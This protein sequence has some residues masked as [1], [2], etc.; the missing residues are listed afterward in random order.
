MLSRVASTLALLCV[1]SAAAEGAT[2]F[3][4]ALRFRVQPT[5]HFRIYFDQRSAWLAPY[6]ATIAEE[7]WTQ[8]HRR[9]GGRA[10][11]MTHVVI[12]DQTDLSNGYATPLPYDTIVIYP[13]WPPGAEFNTDDWLRLVFTHEFTHIV[14]LDRSESWARI[15]RGVFGRTL[16]AFPNLFLPTWQIEGLATY[17]E[18][19]VTGRGRLHAGDFRAIVDE[20]ARTRR[21]EPLDRV[22]G[23]VTDWPGGQAAYAYGAAFH[24]F[25]ADRFGA[26]RLAALA[27]ATAGRLPYTAAPSFKTVFGESLGSLWRDFEVAR[28]RDAARAGPDPAVTRLTSSG[29]ITAAPRFDWTC[30]QCPLSIVYTT[31]TPHEFPSLN[32]IAIDGGAATTLTTRYS[33]ATTAVGK[34]KMYFDQ[35]EVARAVGVYGDLYE[36]SRDSNR[37][38]RLTRG[39]RLHDPD[40]SP[41]GTTIA[42]VQENASRRDLVLVHLTPAISIE[43]VAGGP[44]IHFNAPRWSPSGDRIAVERHVR[45]GDPEIVIMNT[46][47]RVFQVLLPVP[48][49]RMVMPAWRPDGRT[50]VAAVATGNEP[51]NLVEF[52]LDDKRSRRLTDIHGGATWPD[53]SPDGRTIVF[54]GYTSTGYDLFTMAYPDARVEWQPASAVAAWPSEPASV[55]DVSFADSVRTIAASEPAYSPV[56]TLKPTSWSPI[57]V[58][59]SDQ[60][61][62]GAETA[63]RDVLG[64][65]AWVTSAT[66]LVASPSET[67]APDRGVPDWFVSYAYDRWQPVLFASASAQTSFFAGPATSV[68]TPSTATRRERVFEGGVLLPMVRARRSHLALATFFRSADDYTLI[69]RNLRRD[70]AALRSGW[71]TTTAR[72][73]GYSISPEDG[74]IAGATGEFVRS[75]LGATADSTTITGDLRFFAHG[76]GRHHIV[77]GRLAGGAS[78]GDQIAGRTFVLGGSGPDAT[79]LDFGS[80]AISVL[81]GFPSNSFAGSRVALAQLEYRFPL[82]RPQR[83]V[84]TWPLFLHTVHAAAFADFGHAWTSRFNSADVKTSFGGELSTNVVAG[85]YF[86]FTLSVGAARGHDG[87]GTL[88]DRN[89]FYVRLGRSF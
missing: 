86:P 76:L 2:R 53:V 82:A 62:V 89:T 10:P 14:H 39:A 60:V 26:D 85:Y 64:Y 11:R 78:R 37:V 69:D 48:G 49:T 63:G 38:T 68:G 57:I 70:R 24:E 17:E 77:A 35:L 29:F 44:D 81:R 4:P 21:L 40:L 3:D 28:T 54:V 5:P 16:V 31:R 15:V 71:Q 72:T 34:Q 46:A 22:N 51:F 45:G 27:D 79:V 32:R 50:I 9:L 43:T 58:A 83:G 13:T 42:M 61:R 67:A 23:G 55:F 6:L 47:T 56:S 74:L 66:W 59:D 12:A 8:I 87:S 75:A 30:E 33:G 7:T 84:G 80:G 73:Y 36:L 19:T 88:P 65:H 20:A 18:S 41:D 25:L 1:A 52:D